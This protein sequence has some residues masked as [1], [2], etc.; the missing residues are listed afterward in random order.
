MCLCSTLLLNDT[1]RLS[2][3]ATGRGIYRHLGEDM[4]TCIPHIPLNIQCSHHK[5]TAWRAYHGTRTHKRT[6]S[7]QPAHRNVGSFQVKG[8]R[9]GL[10]LSAAHQRDRN[11]GQDVECGESCSKLGNHEEQA[12]T[13]SPIQINTDYL[14]RTYQRTLRRLQIFNV[15][16]IE[17]CTYNI[18]ARTHTHTHTHA[19]THTRTHARTHAHTHQ[20]ET[21]CHTMK[22]NIF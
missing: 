7:N 8:R 13:I 2:C 3:P 11:R 18:A 9:P 10:V 1:S 19:R 17:T 6:H 4:P 14:R 12:C 20:T 5:C 22:Y 15:T 21:A 16:M